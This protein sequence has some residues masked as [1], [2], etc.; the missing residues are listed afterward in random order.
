MKWV[1]SNHERSTLNANPTKWSN[2][3]KKLVSNWATNSLSLFDHF[4]RSPFKGLTDYSLYS[5]LLHFPKTDMQNSSASF[6]R[7]CLQIF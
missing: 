2:T 4:V 3:L 5:K 7:R 6:R 1:E